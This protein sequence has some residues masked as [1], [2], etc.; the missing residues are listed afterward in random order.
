M[1]TRVLIE[2]QL[3]RT[4]HSHLGQI[5]TYSA[6][7]DDIHT[8]IWIAEEFSEEH[9]AALDWQN[10]ITEERFQFF[11]VEIEIWKIGDSLPAP[12]FNVVSKPNNWSRS[13]RQSARRARED[14][15]EIQQLKEQILGQ[16]R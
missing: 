2:N 6:G 3:G 4:D 7:L 13:V 10:E 5:L 12:K 14:L 9:R 16:I 15:S 1:D 8:V 11:G